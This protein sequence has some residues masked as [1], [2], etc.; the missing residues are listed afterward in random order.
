VAA[1]LANVCT[2]NR[3]CDESTAANGVGPRPDEHDALEPPGSGDEAPRVDSPWPTPLAPDAFHG[4]AGEI[5]GAIAP[6]TEADPPALL[7]QFLAAFGNVIG[8]GPHF[9]AD[10]ARHGCK[11]FLGTVGATSK[12]R[13]GT[14]WARAR[15]AF[16]LAAHEWTRDR[17][18]SG[19]SSGEGLIWQIRDPI[20][21]KEKN[22][23]TCE[24]EDVL[25][26]EGVSDKRILVVEP[27]L[28]STMAVMARQGNTLSS[29]VRDAWD[30]SELRALTKNSPARSSGAH[31]SIVGHVTRDELR[32]NLDRTELGNGF[33]NRFL[34]VCAKRA[35]VLP[36]GGVPVDLH[37][38]S[39]RLR[40]AIVFASKAGEI[41][42]AVD[43][44]PIWGSVYADLSE[45]RPGIL[46]AVTARAEAQV[47]RLASIYAMLDSSAEI[48]PAHLRA[49]L[50]MWEYSFASARW[51]WGDSLGDPAADALLAMLRANPN[52]LSSTEIRDGFGHHKADE[53]ARGKG[54]LLS[55]GL[56]RMEHRPT[57]GRSEERW[58]AML[59][60]TTEGGER[61][62][63][64]ASVA[65]VATPNRARSVLP[66]LR[67]G[68][69][70]Q[71][72][73][74]SGRQAE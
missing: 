55:A 24:Y 74:T 36:F 66:S 7:V 10:G 6:Q 9:V 64:V 22:R 43:A 70:R 50:A 2:M 8:N 11:L 53:V 31:V 61:E 54:V 29:V 16:E 33:A 15:Q 60:A 14:S 32:R 72:E 73:N 19:L 17:V 38:L 13:K 1:L 34:W 49:A 44:R 21:K 65:F 5:V 20:Y 4:L 56:A 28:A 27:E 51:V 45:G 40:D 58:F 35:R 71:D 59:Q 42:F 57:K 25:V 3:E 30:R 63:F 48:R 23:K 69:Y 52:G 26:D 47:V 68:V 39:F 37:D 46:G 62:T 18:M 12:G 67:S 41:A